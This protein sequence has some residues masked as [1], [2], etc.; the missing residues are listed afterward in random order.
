[1]P[2]VSL[3]VKQ[4]RGYYFG[5]QLYG[6]HGSLYDMDMTIPIIFSFPQGEGASLFAFLQ[7][8]NGMLPTPPLN[9]RIVDMNRTVHT[10][11]T[12]ENLP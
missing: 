12:G 10:V 3:A 6:W 2:F 9:A 11:L 7:A 8:V 4:Y 5:G 1:M